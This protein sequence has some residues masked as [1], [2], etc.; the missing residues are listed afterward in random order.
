MTLLFCGAAVGE[1]FACPSS[2]SSTTSYITNN[3]LYPTYYYWTMNHLVVP[4]SQQMTLIL[5]RLA[6]AAL[7]AVVLA[8]TLSLM[9]RGSAMAYLLAV[10]GTATP[11]VLFLS[12]SVNPRAWSL[13]GI[14]MAW[15]IIGGLLEELARN[16]R[17]QRRI[18]AQVTAL[19]ASFSLAAMS[20]W[21]SAVMW[22]FVATWG[23]ILQ[24]RPRA[25][26]VRMKSYFAISAVLLMSIPFWPAGFRLAI[27]LSAADVGYRIEGD[28]IPVLV[29]W[30]LHALPKVTEVLGEGEITY[31]GLRMPDLVSVVGITVVGGLLWWA[32]TGRRML[33]T[34]F[35]VATVVFTGLILFA[36]SKLADDL[37]PFDIIAQYVV[38]YVPAVVGL[39]LSSGTQFG[40][41]PIPQRI[42][43]LATWPLILT[44][45]LALFTLVERFVDRQYFGLRLIPRGPATWWWEWMPVGPNVWVAIGSVLF[46]LLVFEI[47]NIAVQVSSNASPRVW[48]GT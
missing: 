27:G 45:A 17:D 30:L 42:V 4:N 43:K 8:I 32:W 38:M 40:R 46:A 48:E 47:R 24:L 36:H 15:P 44:H 29:H 19:V 11:M 10:V 21:D 33:V 6:N 3:G 16:T 23:I 13:A 2:L 7:T 20:R 26:S 25:L 18:A 5:I 28:E 39:L 1:P 12:S 22:A 35:A 14:G 34:L 31:P 9:A 41:R 37:D